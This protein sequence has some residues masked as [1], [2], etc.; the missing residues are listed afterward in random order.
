MVSIMDF[1]A[2]SFPFFFQAKDGIRGIG[3]TGVQTCA[4]PICSG[5]PDSR[6]GR[7]ATNP[8][9]GQKE[10]GSVGY[11]LMEREP[12]SPVF[13]RGP[14]RMA[15]RERERPERWGRSDRKSVV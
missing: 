6:T 13:F 7:S 12:P 2:S 9:P 3:V 10:R 15:S 5:S 8:R 1:M 14:H 4:L 11:I